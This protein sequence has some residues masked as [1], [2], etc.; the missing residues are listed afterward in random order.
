MSDT[1]T[2]KY[3][4]QALKR[5]EDPRFITGTGNYTDDMVLHGMVHAAMVRSPYAH[6]KITGINTDSVKDMPGVIRVLTGQDVADAGLGSIPVGWL[7][8]ELKTP[9]HPAIAL[10]EANHVGDIVAVVIAE[11]RAQ[12]ED[13]AAALEVD[14]EALP[15]VSTSHAAIADGAPLVHDDVPGNVAFRWEIG[16]EAA[17]NEAFSGAAR[18]VSVKLRNHRLVANPIEPRSSLAQFTP[19]G[20][21]YLLYTTSQNPHIH[22]LIIAAFV[23]SIPE[24]KLRVISPD[25]GGGFGT[26][27]FQYQ[28]EVIVLLA[29]R[30]I[31]RPVK[32]TARRSEA[33]V[34]DAQG[35][36]HDTE[37]EL[38]VSDDGMIL[39]FRVNT[40]ANLGAYQTLFAPAVPTYL[41]GTLLNGVYKM[42]AIHAKVTGVMT[43]T[44]P[45]DAYRGAGRPEATYLIERIVDM[46]A[47]EL[48]MDPAELRRKNFIGPDEFPYQTPVAL[49]YDSGDYEPALDQAMQMMN[50]AALREEQARMKGGKKILGVGLISFLEACGLAP[51]ALVGML[52]AQAGQWESSLVRVHPT[53]KVELYTG[54]HSHGQGH[55][56]AF[57]QIAADEL[58]IPIEDIEL[59][60][61]DTGRMP[62]GWGTYGSRSA[63][64]GGS[65]LKMAL[66]KITAK[67]KKIAAH[68]L[69]ASE[70]DIEH[71]GGT[72]RIKGAP[73]KSKSF[74]DIAL[75]A[76]LAHNYPADLEPGLE[77][78]AFYDPKN[79]VYP[80]G[81]HIAV[82]EIDTDTGH[83]K[84]RDYGSVDDCG[85]LI[86]PL[87]AEGQVHGGV[88]QGMGQA[89]L[90]EA[91]YDEDGN[92]LAGTY[93]EYAMPRADDLPFIQHGHTVTPSPH[94]PLGVK[95]IGEAGTIA[96][97]AAVANAVM[98]ALWHEAG[99]AHLDM[100]YTA[101]KVW[102]ALKDARAS[103]PQAA[104]D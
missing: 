39:G 3:F 100:P 13:A 24:H 48:N 26:K 74:F 34:S 103:Q 42:P 75:M 27:I 46:A 50:Y 49:V 65:A 89:L 38:A 33:F 85:P 99:I 88:A 36:D 101:E 83:V 77:A 35:R 90:E 20:G 80:F 70:D 19:A 82:V 4:G 98:D 63:A 68:L 51:S 81:T 11:T 92:L 84:L 12:A 21:D 60:H 54:S 43:N 31:G 28:E 40:L 55:E 69:E 7:L 17:T 1:R 25:V 32:W 94:N 87:I 2:E 102:R 47:H 67:M 66:Q 97:T 30:L 29:A 91:A 76:H 18:K 23:M 61:G 52:G 62:Y 53:G 16:D 93:M 6:A 5:K 58:Q 104:D 71:E 96:S 37:A 86:N 64:V 79:F 8:P 14:Y 45:V 78:T 15:A 59:I 56:T 10:T 73:D 41:Y 22:R 44:V 95:G 57:P 9:A 72:F